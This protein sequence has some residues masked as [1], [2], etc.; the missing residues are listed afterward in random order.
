MPNIDLIY[1]IAAVGVLVA[2][3]HTV[4]SK[5][6]KEEYGQIVTIAGVAIVFL[7]FHYDRHSLTQARTLA[8]DALMTMEAALLI[9]LYGRPRQDRGD[10]AAG[11]ALLLC[12]VS[13]YL[14]GALP[15]LQRLFATSN[16]DGADLPTLLGAG[17]LS[18]GV[19][20]ILWGADPRAVAASGKEASQKAGGKAP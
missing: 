5:A 17:I 13:Q 16:P 18:Y 10:A 14:F 7:I 12:L 9:A 2:I 1:K 11:L 3:L 8:V 4:L 15:G 20:R 19:A 6:G